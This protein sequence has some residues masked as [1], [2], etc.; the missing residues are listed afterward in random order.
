MSETKNQKPIALAADHG[1]YEL[2]EA[3]KSHLAD[4]PKCLLKD[5][6]QSMGF[7]DQ[8][9]FSKCFRQ[10]VGVN[11]KRYLDQVLRQKEKG[12]SLEF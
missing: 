11:P 3:I 12:G 1:G 9:H 8:F 5:L 10:I 6:A 7:A 2:K 4:H